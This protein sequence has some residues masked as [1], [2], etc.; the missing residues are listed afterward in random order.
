MD[1]KTVVACG[2]VLAFVL[3]CL[4]ITAFLFWAFA[5]ANKCKKCGQSH[6]PERIGVR[7][8]GPIV[9]KTLRCPKCGYEYE[10]KGIRT[11]VDLIQR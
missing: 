4:A 11:L 2:L 3:V 8:V 1:V 9:T 7:G 5:R 6:Y 10:A